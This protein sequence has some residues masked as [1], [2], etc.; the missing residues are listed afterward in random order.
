MKAASELAALRAENERLKQVLA[1]I[2]EECNNFVE[3]YSFAKPYPKGYIYTLA[4]SRAG[5]VFAHGRFQV[6][7]KKIAEAI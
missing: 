7:A 6:M 2:Q 5:M 3:A 1:T 4:E